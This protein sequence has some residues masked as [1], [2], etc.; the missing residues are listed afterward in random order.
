[1]N[2]KVRNDSHGSGSRPVVVA[3]SSFDVAPCSSTG[4]GSKLTDIYRSY[5]CHT[6]VSVTGVS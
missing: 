5:H 6:T 3:V 1:M 4:D 2:L